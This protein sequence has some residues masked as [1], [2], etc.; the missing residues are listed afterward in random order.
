MS[1]CGGEYK[2]AIEEEELTELLEDFSN[3]PSYN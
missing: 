3:E 2:M 1:N